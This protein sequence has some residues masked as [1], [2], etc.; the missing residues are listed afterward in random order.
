MEPVDKFEKLKQWYEKKAQV[1]AKAKPLIEAEMDLRK[2][3][4]ALFFPES[5]EGTNTLALQNGW[6]LK[7]I[8]KLDYQIQRDILDEVKDELFALN[9]PLDEIIKYKPFL[10]TSA[11]KT[12]RQLNPQGCDLLDTALVIKLSSP[13]LELVQKKAPK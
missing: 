1:E 12:L 13:T 6:K 4:V 7:Y 8:K 10:S 9:A 3:V 5:K 2:E 11:Y